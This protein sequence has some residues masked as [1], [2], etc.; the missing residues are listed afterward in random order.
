M[1]DERD[2]TQ[3]GVFAHIVRRPHIGGPQI[4]L[5][6]HSYE[7]KGYSPHQWSL[8]GGAPR[9]GE[10]VINALGRETWEETRYR[11]PHPDTP[12]PYIITFSKGPGIVLM[13]TF[14]GEEPVQWYTVD[15]P[16]DL[17]TEEIR[18]VRWFTKKE[19]EEIW[20]GQIYRAQR[21]LICEPYRPVPRPFRQSTL[22][23]PPAA[24]PHE[25]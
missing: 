21:T 2:I 4:L 8:P 25:L 18:D 16:L 9:I 22:G 10:C 6:Q 15:T 13:W 3:V 7:V 11:L 14:H 12:L 19:L 20:E 23:D 5:V 24:P 17:P 1:R